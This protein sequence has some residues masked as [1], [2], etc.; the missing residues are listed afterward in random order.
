L[1]GQSSAF[2]LYLLNRPF[3]PGDVGDDLASV[4][5]GFGDDSHDLLGDNSHD[6]RRIIAGAC[7]AAARRY[8]TR[9]TMT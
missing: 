3:N 8:Q 2:G 1:A 5:I 7:P 6:V 9:P 4:T